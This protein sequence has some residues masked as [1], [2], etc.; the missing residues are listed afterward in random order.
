MLKHITHV[1]VWVHDQDVALDFYVGK[2]GLELREDV[3]MAEFGDYR[4]LTVGP[5][6]QPDVNLILA[7]PGPPM[8]DAEQAA[9]L[10]AAV[11]A[12]TTSGAGSMIL[13]TDD[14]RA[15]YEDLTARGVE[16]IQPPEE[17]FYGIDA[18]FRDPSG[19]AIRITQ[20][21]PGGG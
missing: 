2:L 9:E 11:S 19:N 5:P 13:G 7:T 8:F 14:I 16:F 10:L 1:N 20:R 18:A 15:T 6:G 17:R 3:T 21:A 12:G 4:W